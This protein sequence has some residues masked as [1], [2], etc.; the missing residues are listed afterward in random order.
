MDPS[1]MIPKAFFDKLKRFCEDH[2]L[3]DSHS[4]DHFL[5]VY[6]HALKALKE[7]PTFIGADN[8]R[9]VLYAALLHDVDD[10]KFFPQ[11]KDYENA[12]K[13]LVEGGE[14]IESI[15]M[16]IAM[17]KLVSCSQNGN[18]L[19]MVPVQWMLIPRIS[20]RLEAIGEI[21]I[22]RVIEYGEFVNRQMHNW[23]TPRA[24]NRKELWEIATP[25][26]FAGYCTDK[27]YHDNTTIGHFYDKLLHIGQVENLGTDNPYLIREAEIR[28]EQT[29]EFVLNYWNKLKNEIDERTISYM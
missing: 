12:R 2:K 29:I 25:E 21:G 18:S 11:N 16:I 13:L 17:I 28:H 23:T 3:H 7:H 10:K 20:D 27:K 1:P 8:H 5:A 9:Q 26:R 15:F 24:R 14:T 22:K 4:Y 6:D 19:Q